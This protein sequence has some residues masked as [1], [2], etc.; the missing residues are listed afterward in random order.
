MRYF[1]LLPL[2]FSLI[3][4]EAQTGLKE[5]IGKEEFN[6]NG[7][8][9]NKNISEKKWFV[10]RYSGISVGHNYLYGV[11]NNAFVAAPIGLQLNR[12]LNHNLFGFAGVSVAPVFLSLNQHYLFPGMNKDYPVNSLFGKNNLGLYQKAELGLMYINDA[13]TFSISGSIGV[14]RSNYPVFLYPR[15][16]S[17]KQNSFLLNNN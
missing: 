17:G 5:D 1:F 7:K 14:Q 11:M 3:I 2:L 4:A 6:R 12:R 8:F 13:K 9:H 10:S 16:N 15:M